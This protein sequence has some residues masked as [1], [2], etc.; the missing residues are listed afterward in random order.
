MS[1]KKP[2]G[3]IKLNVKA[4]DDVAA[5]KAEAVKSTAP[6]VVAA[7][8][9]VVAQQALKKPA[10]LDNAVARSGVKRRDA[11]PAIEAALNELREALLR[12]DEL[13]LP[14]LGKIKVMKSKALSGGAEALTL[15]IRTTKTE[16]ID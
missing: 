4:P 1:E 12:G 15:K 5:P 16:V 9:P 6:K 10:F 13:N 3:T 8:Q 7:A 14:P 2:D 11:K